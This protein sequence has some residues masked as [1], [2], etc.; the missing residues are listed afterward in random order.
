MFLKTTLLVCSILIP[1]PIF[2]QDWTELREKGENLYEIKKSYEADFKGKELPKGQGHKQFHRWFNFTEPRAYPSG[3]W[4]NISKA[5]GDAWRLLAQQKNKNPFKT[6]GNWQPLGPA[7]WTNSSYSPGNGR[8]NLLVSHPTDQNIIFAGAPSGGLWK[9]EDEGSSWSPLSDLLPTLGISGIAVHPD[10]PEIIYIGTGDGDGF[11]SFS[12]GVL[13]SIDGGETWN[14]TGLYFPLDQDI[15]INK[16]LMSPAN[17]EIL[18]AASSSG[19][20]KSN[21]GGLTWTEVLGGNIKDIEFHPEDPSLIYA[22]RDR[23]FRSS[24]GG[25]TFEYINENLPSS[26]STQRIAIGVTPDNPEVVYLLIS[27]D[28]GGGLLGV[29]KSADTGVNFELRADSPNILSVN[30]NGTGSTGQGWYDLAIAVDP[31]DENHIFCGGINLWESANGGQTYTLNAKWY[32]EPGMPENFIHADVH[33]L[34]YIGSKF[35]ACTDGGIWR[36][37]DN[38]NSFVDRSNGLEISQ[39]YRLGIAQG[40]DPRVISGLQDNGTM[41]LNEGSWT[42]VQGADGMEAFVHP[43]DNSILYAS[44]QYGGLYKSSNGGSTFA[45]TGSGIVEDGV[46]TVP[47]EMSSSNSE[48]LFVGFQNVWRTTNGGTNWQILS[49]DISSPIHVIALCPSGEERMFASSS[50]TLYRTDND[51]SSWEDISDGLPN[52]F[53]S[54]ILT[55]PTDIDQVWACFSG[56]ESDQKV[57]F[58]SDGGN[59][60]ENIGGGLPNIPTNCLAFDESENTVYIGTDFGVY[61]QHPALANWQAFTTNLPNV[62]VNELEIDTISDRIYAATFG[63]GIWSSNLYSGVESLPIANFSVSNTH[64]CIGQS[65]QFQDLSTDHQAFWSWEFPGGEPVSSSEQNPIVQYSEPGD[66][67]ASLTVLNDFGAV[68]EE[69]FDLLHVFEEAGTQA[70]LAESFEYDFTPTNIWESLA[71]EPSIQGWKWTDVAAATGEHSMWIENASIDVIQE[72]ELI[73]PVVDL[74]QITDTLT[75]WVEFKW[76]YAQMIAANDDRL[77][78]YTSS[79]CGESW[80]LKQQWRGTIDLPTAPSGTI[81]FVPTSPDSWSTANV[82]LDLDE[83]V[84]DFRIKFWFRSDNG[85]NLFLDDINIS[86]VYTDLIDLTQKKATLP[87]PNPATDFIH[88]S[89]NIEFHKLFV[90]DISGR[91]IGCD[92]EINLENSTVKIDTRSLQTG[93]YFCILVGTNGTTCTQFVVGKK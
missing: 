83:L 24:D 78:L 70:P 80:L 43:T 74:S 52:L 35:Y 86:G 41:Y 63:R 53:I 46:W 68:T 56:Y 12:V 3:D 48:T 65:I 64:P 34:L 42:H 45:W 60:W 84:D 18:F 89:G 85:N 67:T 14:T 91:K 22:C 58:S 92:Y 8:I 25:D 62:I 11:D 51:G 93:Y 38:G 32:L 44:T 33:D 9:S 17:S 88:I 7:M 55:H 4:K 1:C 5:H 20:Y 16:L 13:K 40:G 61:I 76:A 15:R 47:W 69:K 21:N 30:D 6:A 29:Y 19:L 59:N 31:N 36:S 2:A 28:I 10:N 75:G 79:D 66:Y 23:F 81:P 50:G 49:T 73:S 71:F 26:S 37:S 90:T 77:R 87:F 72:F 57:Y 39:C 27:A 82:E 54:D